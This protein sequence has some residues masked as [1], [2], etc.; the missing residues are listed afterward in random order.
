MGY[1]SFGLQTSLSS[2]VTD[3][4]LNILSGSYDPTKTNI[5]NR[6]MQR[7]VP[8]GTLTGIGISPVNF[9]S[10][11]DISGTPNPVAHGWSV[12][13][14]YPNVVSKIFIPLAPSTS[15]LP[16]AYFQYNTMTDTWTYIGKLNLTLNTATVHTVRSIAVDDNSNLTTGWS[17]HVLTTNATAANGGYFYAPNI[18][19]ADFTVGGGTVIPSATTGDT[20]ASKKV[21][22]MQETGGTNT[23][24][25]GIG[26][27]FDASTKTIYLG[28]ATT[29]T[30][31]YK[32]TYNTAITSVSAS[33]VTS[34]C[35]NF[36]TGANTQFGTVLQT[37]NMKLAI[38][39]SSQNPSLI[40]QKC[41]YI[42][43]TTFG[44]HFLLSDLSSGSTTVPSFVTWNKLGV[45]NDYSAV[46]WSQ[47]CWS[48]LLD[49]EF[50]Y[51]TTGLFMMKRSIN[52]DPNIRI[53]GKN[54]PIY[55]EASG[56]KEPVAFAGLTIPGIFMSS[57]LLIANSTVAGQRGMY[58]INA[59][60]DQYFVK[61]YTGVVPPTFLITP[62]IKIDCAKAI[63]NAFIAEYRVGGSLPVVQYR[64][65]N[66]NVF[67]GAWTDMP[68][69]ND[70]STIGGLT[71]ISQVQYRILFSNIGDY[72][73]NSQIINEIILSY[74][75]KFDTSDSWRLVVDKTSRSGESP[76]L[77]AAKQV[78]A[79]SGGPQT[80]Y[81]NLY[82]SSKNLITQLN[83]TTH[84]SQFNKST[85]GGVTFT[86]MTGANDYTNTW[87][88]TTVIQLNWAAPVAGVT[89][90]GV[91]DVA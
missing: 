48:N 77:V 39:K 12:D 80:I 46:T 72:G 59:A 25:V 2:I 42:S 71:N 81:F 28:S 43:S 51:S 14:V 88:G 57:G 44:F 45:G 37:N 89:I 91:R 5:V 78:A 82:D 74:I 34:D 4:S 17:I 23:L 3:A 64:T 29:N 65:S 83:T 11:Q 85:D 8:G 13:P 35:Y 90:V 40:G 30:V 52:N 18:A 1:K 68:T 31:F 33:G 36:K 70:L 79:Y 16:I 41:G 75:G 61:T 9:L 47:S 21:F 50:A 49:C 26:K 6:A 56:V 7:T 63:S 27:F 32:F 15:N 54:D 86:A 87:D 53:F 19:A 22:W 55:A 58:A 69:N 84:Y 76:V 67:P 66:F 38:P 10:T 60:A 24:T 62:V 20:Q 73:T